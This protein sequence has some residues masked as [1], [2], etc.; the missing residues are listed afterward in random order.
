MGS[1]LGVIL[2]LFIF[3]L[4]SM[5]SLDLIL[6]KTNYSYV[7]SV[8][9]N[10][11]TIFSRNGGI[12]AINKVKEFIIQEL[13]PNAILTVINSNSQKGEIFTFSISKLYKP[14]FINKSIN[15]SIRRS[16]YIGAFIS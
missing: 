15:I 12:S 9:A 3:F 7:E 11:S 4:V 5:F 2:S 14:I 8:A 1:K 10:S 6:I 13:G 16:S